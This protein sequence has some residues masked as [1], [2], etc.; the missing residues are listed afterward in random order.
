DQWGTIQI[1]SLTFNVAKA[2]SR[3]TI[4]TVDQQTGIRGKEPITTLATYRRW[5][6]QI[7]FGQNL[8]Q[9]GDEMG[10]KVAGELRL[11]DRGTLS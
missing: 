11:G 10:T 1:G 2:C 6:G 5:D 8:V 3:C 9:M 7:W 4:P